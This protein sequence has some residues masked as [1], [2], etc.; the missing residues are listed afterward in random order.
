MA[1]EFIRGV[2][3]AG[4]LVEKVTLYDKTIGF[5]KGCLACQNTQRCTIHDDADTIAQKMLTADVI[6]FAA[7]I[8]YYGMCGQMKTMLDRA[9]PFFP[10]DY[11]F[12]DIYLLAAA[13]EE[14]EHT[15]DGAVTGLQGWIDC[16]E[17]ARL[18]GTV[19]AGGVTS[20]GAIKGHPALEKAWEL[21]KHV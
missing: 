11:Q 4:N 19:F 3:E 14:N 9:N 6:A 8:Y 16:F 15:V 10:A 5:C 7:P 17:K 13:A 12:R 18:T 2:Q 20:V 21:G 1:D